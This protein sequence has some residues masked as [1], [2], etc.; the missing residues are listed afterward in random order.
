MNSKILFSAIVQKYTQINAKIFRDTARYQSFNLLKADLYLMGRSKRTSDPLL[1]EQKRVKYRREEF[2]YTPLRALELKCK[3]IWLP[4]AICLQFLISRN[5][6]GGGFSEQIL[7]A[8][9]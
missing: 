6:I 8:R 7:F 2:F 1:C 9:E 3:Q 4:F 5:L